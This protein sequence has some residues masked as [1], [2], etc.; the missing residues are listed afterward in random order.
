MVKIVQK[1][2]LG[3]QRVY[4]LGVTKDHNF[5]LN[6]GIVASNCF[7]KSHSTAY[8]YVTY[9]TAYLKANYPV[10]YMTALLTS[11][12]D[13]QD[14]IEKYRENCQKIGIEVL[15]PDINRSEKD[16]TPDGD[17]ILFGLSAVKNLGEAAID[18]ILSAREKVGGKFKSLGD[19]CS[20]VDLRSVNR[21]AL[22]TLIKC[23]AFDSIKNNRHQLINDLDLVISWAQNRAKEKS[24]GQTNL[25]DFMAINEPETN[26]AFE[27]EPTSKQV[28]DYSLP[29]KLRLEKENLG[30][31]ISEHP[32]K[33][34]QQ[35]A[36]LFSPI[37][38]N[39]L[40][41]Q[42]SRKKVSVI[43]MITE[44]KKIMTK[45]GDPMA[46]VQFEDVTGQA[47]GVIFPSTYPQLELILR[48]DLP[49]I[50][51][52]KVEK[53]DD[54]T[55]LIVEDAKAVE[56]VKLVMLD[57]PVEIALDN[58]KSY[59]LKSIIQEQSGEKSVPKVPVIAVVRLGTKTKLIRF[60]EDFWVQD[61][62]GL[63]NA[64]NSAGFSARTTSLSENYLK[65]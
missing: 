10:E 62:Q 34:I 1:K 36:K 37:N 27:Q 12:S 19:F 39:Q 58:T 25:F 47:E 40:S 63:V 6:S 32:L 42:K 16:F 45:K 60:G 26:V 57:L 4:D 59:N 28:E 21:R 48:E 29:E 43:V 18:N 52:G 23:G 2:S 22:E 54:Q 44:I 9:Q 5:L 24:T 46:F 33:S 65:S 55:Q 35:S 41:E 51:W 50:V 11:S 64:L 8:A 20:N 13:N 14:K 53:K 38:L 31:Y 17:K 15:P 56:E 30:F 7:N 3:K 49:L 61:E